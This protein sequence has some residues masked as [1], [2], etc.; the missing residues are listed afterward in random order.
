M[1][2]PTPG[3]SYRAADGDEDRL[4][5]DPAAAS[6]SFWNLSR[7]RGIA[8]LRGGVGGA[9]TGGQPKSGMEVR[10]LDRAG[11][12]AMAANAGAEVNEDKEQSYRRKS[13]DSNTSSEAIDDGKTGQPLSLGQQISYDPSDATVI[14]PSEADQEHLVPPR[15]DQSPYSPSRHNSVSKLSSELT[16]SDGGDDSDEMRCKKCGGLKFRAKK[17]VGRQMFLCSRCGTAWGG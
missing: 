9:G 15:P 16:S 12:Q 14:S 7:W 13:T 11:K 2:P 10:A 8:A 4:R 3:F 6:Y 1:M 17:V 5:L